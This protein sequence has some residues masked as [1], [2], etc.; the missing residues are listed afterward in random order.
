MFARELLCECMQE[1]QPLLERHY[2][3]L[4]RRKDIV[5]L[6]PM[7]NEY[8]LLERLGRFMVFT[9]RGEAGNLIGYNAFF[10]N[11]HL[12][13]ASLT[14]AQNDVFWIEPDHRR[15]TLALRFLRYCEDYLNKE[16][17]DKVVYHCKASNNFGPIL[18]RLGYAD[19]ETMCG[20]FLR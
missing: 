19:E 14:V 11:K 15:G 18:H 3:E 7:W 16:G 9:A 1:A 13:Y 20:K 17:V 6:D 5:V 12:H 2:G 4:T 8:A 10:V